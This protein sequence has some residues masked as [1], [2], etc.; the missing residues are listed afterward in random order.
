MISDWNVLGG[1]SAL[2]DAPQRVKCPFMRIREHVR[3]EWSPCPPSSGEGERRAALEG[4]SD[5]VHEGAAQAAAPVPQR[6][7]RVHSHG[8]PF[9][10]RRGGGRWCDRSRWYGHRAMPWY[11]RGE[12]GGGWFMWSVTRRLCLSGIFRPGEK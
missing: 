11:C 2:G 12:G 5:R 6:R 10:G 3:G 7:R 9:E 1:H 8:K 4:A